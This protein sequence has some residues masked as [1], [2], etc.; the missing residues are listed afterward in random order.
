MLDNKIIKTA[1]RYWH[2]LRHLRA[3]QIYRRLYFR[4][5]RPKADLSP[6]PPA[7]KM[8]GCWELPARRKPSLVAA[9]E[10]SFLNAA[11]NLDALGW[12]D[13]GTDKLWRYNQHYFD[14]LNARDAH[15]RNDWHLA[16][17]ADWSARNPP[18]K[19]SG[20]EPYPTSLRIVN[21]IKW[22]LAGNDLTP[23]AQHSLAIQ[24]RWLTRRLERHL[25]GNHLFANAKA[26]IFVGLWFAGGEAR[27]WLETGM[28]ILAR[29]VPEQILPD[30]GQ[31]EL[32]PMY[33]ALA[34]EDMLDLI[35]ITRSYP[36]ALNT[37]QQK[38][39]ADWQARLPAM[40]HW[41]HTLCHPD[42]RIA[43]FNDAAFGIAPEVQ[44][45]D[46]YANRLGFPAPS[47]SNPLTWLANSGYGRLSRD[48]GTLLVDMARVGPD[49]LPGHAH[50]DTLSFEFSLFGQRIIVNS[51]TSVYGTGPER[52]RQRG[53][54]AHSTVTVAGRDSSEVW[55]GFRVARRAS[56]LSA[57][58]YQEGETL[59]AEG[60]HDGYR[61]LR[62]RPVHHRRWEL[63]QGSLVVEDRLSDDHHPAEARFHLH[64]DIT[65]AQT[66]P[67]RGTCRLPNGQ[68]LA[69]KVK[70]GEARLEPSTW[71]PEFGLSLPGTCIVLPLKDGQASFELVWT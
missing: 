53:T 30:G 24:A 12:D 9:C 13:P 10:F 34:L 7:R 38:Q 21:W 41:L 29:E 32:S 16:L 22:A 68:E 43:F 60:S 15:A 57:K 37:N 62:G 56:I 58:L 44:E 19:G 48:G 27:K 26:L 66:A 11:G 14:D 55:S 39:R 5:A 36:A 54:A 20:W 70:A 1:G 71:H 3:G 49:Y 25:L 4:S 6:A 61:R 67:D 45:L 8:T 50:A 40:R 47:A 46:A 69:W 52:L 35:N 65:A 64:P 59:V 31:F 63:S 33:H 17:M 42:G 18:G 28:G 2:T 51:G 23:E